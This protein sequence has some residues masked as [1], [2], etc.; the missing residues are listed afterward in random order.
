[1]N[2][3]IGPNFKVVFLGKKKK[4]LVGLVN[5]ARDP[6]KNARPAKCGTLAAIQT[7]TILKQLEKSFNFFNVIG[8]IPNN[9][10]HRIIINALHFD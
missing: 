7:Y 4:V 1:M 5:S 9:K 2:S 3:I 6:L 8:L 10:S